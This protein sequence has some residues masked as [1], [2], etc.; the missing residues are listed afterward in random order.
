[1][2]SGRGFYLRQQLASSA[3]GAAPDADRHLLKLVVSWENGAAPGQWGQEQVRG[4]TNVRFESHSRPQD[5]LASFR[6]KPL[7][8]ATLVGL[9][10]YR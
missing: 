10:P 2:R 9:Q 5:S 6:K 7:R 4:G 1:M 3:N 8:Y